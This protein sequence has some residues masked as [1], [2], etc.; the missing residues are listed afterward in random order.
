M[1]LE[2]TARIVKL[3]AGKKDVNR[4]YTGSEKLEDDLCYR[5]IAATA[6]YG[7]TGGLRS[8]EYKTTRQLVSLS[9]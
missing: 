7:M 4:F 9:D 6:T 3:W 2:N 1:Y 8:S 5:L